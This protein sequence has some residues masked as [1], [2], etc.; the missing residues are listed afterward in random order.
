MALDTSGNVLAH[1][2]LKGVGRTGGMAWDGESLWIA[3]F[4]GKLWR[5][6]GDD[7]PINH[8]RLTDHIMP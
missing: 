6:Y 4:E 2:S 1:Y 5:I 8:S 7:L 3:E